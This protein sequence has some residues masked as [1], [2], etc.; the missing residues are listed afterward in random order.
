[1]RPENLPP[2][3]D[4][5]DAALAHTWQLL[6]RGAAD[7]RS[8]LHTPVVAT[9]DARGA[10]DARVMVLREA[11]QS[12]AQLRFHTDS[13]SDKAQRIGSG[14]PVSVLAYHPNEHIQLRLAGTGR[15]DTSSDARMQ[16][17][18]RTSLY[19]KRCYLG[20]VG[21]GG[22][23]DMPTSGLPTELEGIE[24]PLERTLPG[25]ANFALLWVDIQS[26]EWLFLAHVGHRRARFERDASSW[27]GRWLIP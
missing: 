11:R 27:A 22:S 10:P 2:H 5:L 12:D 6:V 15:I 13:R 17:W 3:Y 18:D 19:G 9:C 16:A 1:M 14:A 7:R 20:A 26:I 24:P 23:S 21:P 25:L 8:P 4:D